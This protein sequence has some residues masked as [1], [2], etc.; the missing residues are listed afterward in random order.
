MNNPMTM[1][2]MSSLREKHS[3][4]RAKRLMRVLKVRCGVYLRYLVIAWDCFETSSSGISGHSMQMPMVQ[5]LQA[6]IAWRLMKSGSCKFDLQWVI[7]T[8]FA[9]TDLWLSTAESRCLALLTNLSSPLFRVLS[10]KVSALSTLVSNLN[11]IENILISAIE[12]LGVST[13]DVEP[14]SQSEIL[15]TQFWHF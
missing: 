14:N 15:N 11:D 1:S 4:R 8:P 7:K 9:Q 5:A 12:E 6:I 13:E 10:R 3:V 2:C